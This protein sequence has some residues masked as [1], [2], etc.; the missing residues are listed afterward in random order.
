[1]LELD[2]VLIL[3]NTKQ[4]AMSILLARGSTLKNKY[5]SIFNF[6]NV[7]SWSLKPA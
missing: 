6:Y 3:H 4:K 1:M 7:G 2:P 5:P